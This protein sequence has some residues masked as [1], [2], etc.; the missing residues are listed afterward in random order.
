[1]FIFGVCFFLLFSR[2]HWGKVRSVFNNSKWIDLQLQFTKIYGYKE[3]TKT[4]GL[5]F[6]VYFA[7]NA[8]RRDDFPTP[9]A[10]SNSKIKR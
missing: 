6:F 1:M 9:F 4:T 8:F 10:P 3:L 7:D 2:V 5:S